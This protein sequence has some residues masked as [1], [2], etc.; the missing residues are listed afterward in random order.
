MRCSLEHLMTRMRF[1]KMQANI[2]DPNINLFLSPSSFQR[3]HEIE[4]PII[5]S[6]GIS[7]SSPKNFQVGP[8]FGSVWI[9][10]VPFG[11]VWS[12]I[13][14]R[15]D[16]PFGSWIRL[17]PRLVPFGSVWFPVWF[18]LDPNIWISWFFLV[19]TQRLKVSWGRKSKFLMIW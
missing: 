3:I 4:I 11:S 12:P 15:L 8:L 13:W 14:F 17:V 5:R 16:P 10:L 18:R 6:Q 1:C 7:I 19:M 9:R 2:L